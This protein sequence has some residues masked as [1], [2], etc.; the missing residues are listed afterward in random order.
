MVGSIDRFIGNSAW[1]SAMRADI[2]R[3]A[4]CRSNVLITGPSGTGKEL[5]A[6]AIHAHSPQAK[7][8][9][10][11]VDCAAVTSS[12]FSAHLF[13]YVKG[14]FTGAD[15]DA[16]GCFRAAH[17]GTIF[18]DEIGE[19]ELE[20]QSRL[21][22]VLQQRTVTPV[23][24]HQEFPVDV[25]VISA[26]NC[27]LEQ[28][29][30]GGRFR[31]DLYYRLNVIRLRTVPLQ[32]HAEDIEPLARHFFAH[33]AEQEGVPSTELMPRCLQHMC[34]LNWPGNV[35]ELANFVERL[36]VLGHKDGAG[37]PAG[38]LPIISVPSAESLRSHP[39]LPEIVTSVSAL[40]PPLPPDESP[41]LPAVAPTSVSEWPALESVEHEHIHKTLVHTRYNLTAAAKLLKIGRQQLTR[42][43]AKYGLATTPRR[44]GR[45]RSGADA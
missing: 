39:A 38:C 14:A 30:D 35:R 19:L 11:T 37:L 25:R 15:Q 8:P 3:V 12:L 13:G 7:M 36:V 9:F 21:L 43:I 41:S 4:Q 45:P 22:R 2:L 20:L 5:I 40:A 27:D 42:K 28:A 18:L 17:G 32:N 1:A 26:T 31:E 23:G 16:I 29:V 44:R 34:S 10:V 24:N 33:F 6:Q